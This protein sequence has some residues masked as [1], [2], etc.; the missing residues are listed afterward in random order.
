MPPL[1]SRSAGASR[2]A[3]ISSIGVTVS[4]SS[5]RSSAVRSCGDTGIDF[6]V[7]GQTPPPSLMSPGS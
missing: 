5:A 3:R 2:I 7:R 4:T 1:N 6:A